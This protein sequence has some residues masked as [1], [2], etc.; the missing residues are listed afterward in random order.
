MVE[1]ATPQPA[2]AS[3]VHSAIIYCE[4]CR[5]ETEHR[6]L[7]VAGGARAHGE[8][9][10]LA[11]CRECRLTH[12]FEDRPRQ[13]VEVGE[14]VSEGRTSTPGRRRLPEDSR[15]YVG[16]GIPGS[17]PPVAV[18]RIDR[19]DGRRVQ[20]AAATEIATLWVRVDRGA[21]VPVSIIEGRRTRAE[22][23]VVP[24]ETV[25]EVGGPL[26]VEERSLTIVGLRARGETWRH[27]GARFRAEE[28]Q[29]I[30]AR[31]SVSPPEGSIDWS[32][33]R[34]RPS[35]RESSTSASDRFRSSPGVSRYRTS[36]RARSDAGGPTDHSWESS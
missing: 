2:P 14:V 6:I 24:P 16:A 20:E 15:V 17:E 29:R 12:P 13:T 10:G 33:S 1:Q 34:D 25:Y 19:K 7:K 8:L 23:L 18:L 32:R 21:V 3:A 31:R 22:R 5:R 4:S 30:Y 9:R 11:R 26:R 36:P 35:S 27:P 28:V